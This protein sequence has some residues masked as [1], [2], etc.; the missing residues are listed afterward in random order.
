MTHCTTV[1]FS[2]LHPHFNFNCTRQKL[3]IYEKSKE[4]ERKREVERRSKENRE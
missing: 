2:K 1:L 4:R 3:N